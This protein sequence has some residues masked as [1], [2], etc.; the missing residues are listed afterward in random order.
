MRVIEPAAGAHAAGWVGAALAGA[1]ALQRRF[2]AW[3]SRSLRRALVSWETRGCLHSPRGA[4]RARLPA[5]PRCPA[6]RLVPPAVGR[7]HCSQPPVAARSGVI[8]LTAKVSFGVLPLLSLGGIVLLRKTCLDPRYPF[9][10][11]VI[12]ASAQR[13]YSSCFSWLV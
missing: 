9:P 10:L 3:A 2:R 4:T 5:A 12:W 1:L 8:R 6:A 13:A 11:T 7:Q